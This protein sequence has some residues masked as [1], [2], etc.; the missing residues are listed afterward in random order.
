M[1]SFRR[2][3]RFP[4][5]VAPGV[6][7]S[8]RNWA[9]GAAAYVACWLVWIFIVFIVYELIYSFYRRWRVSEYISFI[10]SLVFLAVF[11]PVSLCRVQKVGFLDASCANE[12]LFHTLSCR[13]G[14]LC[15]SV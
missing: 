10:F 14:F 12:H 11:P 3:S 1:D 8:G 15:F 9:L 2:V 7:G 6:P 4:N 5:P 13:S